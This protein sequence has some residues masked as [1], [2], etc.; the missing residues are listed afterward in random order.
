MIIKCGVSSHMIKSMV[1]LY[2]ALKIDTKEK[3]EESK[4]QILKATVSMNNFKAKMV[5]EKEIAFRAKKRA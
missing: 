3:L 4:K 2:N 5:Q 1:Q